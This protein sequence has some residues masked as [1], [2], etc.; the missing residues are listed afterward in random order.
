[1]LQVVT[2][3]DEAMDSRLL[4]LQA[5]DATYNNGYWA[6]RIGRDV[7]FKD[8]VGSDGI[9]YVEVNRV[10]P[11]VEAILGELFPN[12]LDVEMT[13]AP[14]DSGDEV[15]ATRA[16]KHWLLSQG[17]AGRVKMVL[18]QATLFDGAGFKIGRDMG[19][20]QTGGHK[21]NAQKAVWARVVPW[22]EIVLDKEVHDKED[23]RYIGHLYWV[24]LSDARKRFPEVSFAGA[25]RPRPLEDGHISYTDRRRAQ[26]G[27]VDE[28]KFV[29]ILEWYNLVDDYY[30][31]EADVISGKPN[32]EYIV[33]GEDGKLLH[34]D[35][36]PFLDEFGNPYCIRGR[37]EI[38][39]PEENLKTP[40][41]IFPIPLHN[42]RGKPQAP[43]VPCIL[44]HEVTY[45]LKGR[46]IVERSFD[47]Q[48]EINID[49]SFKATATR[50]NGRAW[51]AQKGAIDEKNMSLL[52]SGA[53]GV[54]IEVEPQQEGVPANLSNVMFPVPITTIPPDNWRYAVEVEADLGRVVATPKFAMGE[55]TGASATEV[56]HLAGYA[57]NEV[58]QYRNQ[59]DA[60]LAEVT[61]LYLQVQVAA[62]RALGP[63]TTIPVAIPKRERDVD[64][65]TYEEVGIPDLD[66]EFTIAV[67][68]GPSGPVQKAQ[69]QQRLAT[70]LPMVTPLFVSVANG[71]EGS[72]G[73]ALL[74]DTL[75]DVMELPR[76]LSSQSI[77]KRMRK[78][79][80]IADV[81]RLPGN[82]SAMPGGGSTPTPESPKE[83]AGGPQPGS[84][85][86]NPFAGVSQAND[87]S[88]G[89]LNAEGGS[90]APV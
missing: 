53:D 23:Q 10:A 49:R 59:R 67:F 25:V 28:E 37:Q 60:W 70:M 56:N 2:D 7:R 86:P 20:I 15:K 62:M 6:H 77:R 68:Q 52:Q 80:T 8:V 4:A 27:Q 13:P 36:D 29:R 39:L 31:G 38:Y 90:N 75:V 45:P 22:W 54:I 11:I 1:V 9:T 66:G 55:A 83:T 44:N 46:S 72:E 58:G 88:S 64:G 47:Q 74:L 30:L 41:R 63:A 21:V 24:P 40:I 14:G 42:G 69:A 78:G 3:F 16:V 43:L 17:M 33:Y 82:M 48:R 26:S 12:T 18:S 84:P 57:Q 34:R 76:D 32:D 61:S 51:L 81:P 85:P 5:Y 89:V 71:G 87:G 73:N 79:G 65:P 19:I 50:R 35:K